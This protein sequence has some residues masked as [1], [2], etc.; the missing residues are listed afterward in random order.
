MDVTKA[1]YSPIAKSNNSLNFFQLLISSP[2]L[3]YCTHKNIRIS[4]FSPTSFPGPLCCEACGGQRP[5]QRLVTWTNFPIYLENL[6]QK[7]SAQEVARKIFQLYWKT[8]SCDNQP[9]PGPSILPHV[10]QQRPWERGWFLS[11]LHVIGQKLS[12][13]NIVFKSW[14]SKLDTRLS[15]F[16]NLL[17]FFLKFVK[18]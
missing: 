16:K 14:S 18:C 17:T 9:L 13:P 12:H 5:W 15:F 1:H 8:W 2:R 6:L 10:P 4:C 11:Y 7:L 3:G